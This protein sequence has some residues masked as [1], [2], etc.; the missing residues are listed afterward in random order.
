M[1]NHTEPNRVKTKPTKKGMKTHVMPNGDI[2]T[3]AKHTKNSK[4]VKKAPKKKKKPM[5]MR[6]SNVSY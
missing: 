3:G 6:K 4:L 2:H 5:G 1:Y